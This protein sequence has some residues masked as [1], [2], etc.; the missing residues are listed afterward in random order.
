MPG[1]IKVF[2]GV[3]IPE[4]S[5]AEYQATFVG[6]DEA[7]TALVPG[8]VA[9][10]TATL[11]RRDGTVINGRSA[12]NVLNAN[13]GTLDGAGVF[14]LHLSGNDNAVDAATPA[15]ALELRVLT[16]HV[17][18]AKVGGGTGD[19]YAERRFYVRNLALVS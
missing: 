10:I 14:R 5:E 18:Y 12:Q 19:L 4:R 8:A 2:A 7:E 15:G 6:A 16:L 3:Q 17:T 13:G 11:T 1:A 9:A